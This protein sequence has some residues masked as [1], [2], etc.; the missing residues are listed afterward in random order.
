MDF[1]KNR[2]DNLHAL[3]LNLLFVKRFQTDWKVREKGLLQMSTTREDKELKDVTVQDL[4]ISSEKV[5]HVQ[6]NNPLEHALLVLVKS[7]YFAVPVLDASNKLAG[8]ISKTVILDQILGIDRYEVE[9]LSNLKVHEVM[10]DDL[11]SIQK[12]AYFIDGL[13]AVIDAPFVCVVDEEGYFEG[14]LTRRAILK[15]LKREYYRR[16]ND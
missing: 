16:P 9:K 8:S 13:K 11:V 1:L 14:I 5:A 4:M 3:C 10:K 12:S 6:L 7:G 2:K 15:L